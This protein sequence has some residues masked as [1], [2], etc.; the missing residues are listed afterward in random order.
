MTMASPLSLVT[1]AAD[2]VATQAPSE[3]AAD[4]SEAAPPDGPKEVLVARLIGGACLLLAVGCAIGA[5][6]L[7]KLRRFYVTARGNKRLVKM[8]V[9]DEIQQTQVMVTLSAVKGKAKAS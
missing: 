9:K 8:E 6:K 5:R 4:G 2:D 7:I 3:P 1:G